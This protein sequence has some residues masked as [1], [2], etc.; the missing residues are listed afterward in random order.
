VKRGAGRFARTFRLLALAACL[1]ALAGH[2]AP[3][4]AEP[5]KGVDETVVEKYAEEAGRTP[6][7]PY[8]KGDLLLFMFL[9]AGAVGGFIGGYTFRGLFPPRKK[10][11]RG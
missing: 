11:E 5:W 2:P 8:I 3:A 6:S 4:L 10:T 9:T 7:E 1:L